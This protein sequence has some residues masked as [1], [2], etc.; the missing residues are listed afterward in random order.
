M[1]HGETRIVLR[2]PISGN[3]LKDVTSENSFQSGVIQQ[4]M[5]SIGAVG[6]RLYGLAK[7]STTDTGLVGGWSWY[8]LLGGI[9]LFRDQ[10]PVGDLYMNPGNQMVGCGSFEVSNSESPNELGSYNSQESSESTSVIKQVYDFATNQANGRISC[11]S[12]TS[13]TGG[14]IGYGNPSGGI[15]ASNK[16]IS[17]GR[18]QN[19]DGFGEGIAFRNNKKYQFIFDTYDNTKLTISKTYIPVTQ[20]SIKNYMEETINIDLTQI[21]TWYADFEVRNVN[22]DGRY[23]Y[24]SYF[25]SQQNRVAPNG[26]IKYLKYDLDTDTITQETFVN[27]SD[28]TLNNGDY[29]FRV[30][31]GYAF[32]L[33]TDNP[34]KTEVINLSTGINVKEFAYGTEASLFSSS[35]LL[36]VTSPD[37][38]P[39]I[40]DMTNDTVYPTNA[41]WDVSYGFGRYPNY[42][43]S[44]NC[45]VHRGY[46]NAMSIY[47]P[48]WY[49]ATINNLQNAVTKTPAQTMKVTYT[50]TE[51]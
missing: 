24:I 17:P 40:Y 51:A 21:G 30:A 9:F 8:N 39:C 46:G 29:G 7:G 5:R 22:Q 48:P 33:T 27:S 45:F 13:R 15:I 50:L 34:Q 11:V 37:D 6:N 20:S 42:D 26:S 25:S 16:M 31:N 41:G 19:R 44:S 2:N 32:C 1:I 12:L 3:I 10:I 49:L 28:K 36:L 43:E 4:Y 23:V 18:W 14:Y 47:N 35:G 38:R